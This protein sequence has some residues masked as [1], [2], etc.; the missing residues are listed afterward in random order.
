MLKKESIYLK[1]IYISYIFID[2]LTYLY[3]LWIDEAEELIFLVS[4]KIIIISSIF[5]IIYT[6][7]KIDLNINLIN[8]HKC[9]KIFFNLFICSNYLLVITIF[10]CR[11]LLDWFYTIGAYY[12][13]RQI[14]PFTLSNNETQHEERVCKLYNIYNNS[15]YKYQYICSYKAFI[16]EKKNYDGMDMM[17][18]IPKI[19]DNT[20]NNIIEKFTKEHPSKTLYYCSRINRLKKNNYIKD[21]YCNKKIN[22]PLLFFFIHLIYYYLFYL[23]F[24]FIINIYENSDIYLIEEQYNNSDFSSDTATQCSENN[25]NNGSSYIKQDDKNIIVENNKVYE[26]EVNIKNF[27]ENKNN[28][29]QIINSEENS[30]NENMNDTNINFK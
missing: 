22:I 27:A 30:I 25:I 13:Y 2:I 19:R 15:R 16:E 3:Y 10:I 17:I 21:E 29:E 8:M 26:V 5:C 9:Q 28:M 14:C 20:K 1:L 23:H 18:C 11:S 12:E 4:L 6:F 24:K 7:I